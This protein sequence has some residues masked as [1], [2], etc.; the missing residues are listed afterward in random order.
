M[1]RRHPESGSRLTLE[2]KFNQDSGLIAYNPAI[3][4]RIDGDDLRRDQL[5]AAPILILNVNP[6]ARKKSH[7]SMLA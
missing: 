7:M 3:V 5:Q 6:A 2:I 1:R 4:T